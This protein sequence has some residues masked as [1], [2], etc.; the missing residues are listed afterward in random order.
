MSD[1]IKKIKIKQSD[2]TFSDYIP[3][4]ANAKDVDM[5]NGYSL[6][7][8]IGTIDVDKEGSIAKQLSKTTK[9]YDSVA[10]MKADTQL[11]GG[12]A[13]V[14]LGY[15]K[16]NDGG[17]ALYQIIDSTDE[18]Y[19]SLVD[20]GGSAH[21]LKNNLKAKLII[22]DSVNI[23]QFGAYGDG[24]HDD[25]GAIQ[26]TIN[27]IY[28]VYLSYQNDDLANI[29]FKNK[30]VI[31][32][33]PGRYRITDTIN[34]SI[35]IRIQVQGNAEIISDFDGTAIYISS[36]LSPPYIPGEATLWH[37]GYIG[38][39][40]IDSTVG[41][42]TIRKKESFYTKDSQVSGSIGLEIGNREQ[43]SS[44]M[45]ISRCS[46]NNINIYEFETALALNS[47]D[48]YCI[49][50]N[51]LH[52]E[53]NYYDIYWSHNSNYLQN[54]GE[55]IVFKDC[56]VAGAQYGLYL[57]ASAPGISF[58]DCS[59][60]FL[61]TCFYADGTKYNLSSIINF[62]NGHIEAIGYHKDGTILDSTKKGF[63]YIGYY[64]Y[65]WSTYKIRLNI[66]GTVLSLYPPKTKAGYKFGSSISSTLD[67]SYNTS[68][69]SLKNLIV[70]LKNIR[71]SYNLSTL[72]V[73]IE[74]MFLAESGVLLDYGQQMEYSTGCGIF[75]GNSYDDYIG[76]FISINSDNFSKY[77]SYYNVDSDTGVTI[78]TS[79]DSDSNKEIPLF[80]KALSFSKDENKTAFTLDRLKLRNTG[81]F[82]R[83]CIIYNVK[84]FST[85]ESMELTDRPTIAIKSY[86]SDNNPIY[87]YYMSS[88]SMVID[89]SQSEWKAVIAHFPVPIQA[90]YFNC[91]F[92]LNYIDSNNSA[93]LWNGTVN[94]A[95]FLVEFCN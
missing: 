49:T 95:G 19:E 47:T 58:E 33:I 46:F 67:K 83:V 4:G 69:N 87:S 11:T 82:I 44:Y 91:S 5:A 30:N 24:E 85:Q 1:R 88:N 89:S 21:D 17:G 80:T 10:D 48:L 39:S 59:F 54:S 86:L 73:E 81:K 65:L 57:N 93:K 63:G 25:T 2:G 18:D 23:K 51:N 43:Q 90:D 28:N 27:Y 38:G 3:I 61:G 68:A 14:T 15:Y 42:L 13:A 41:S 40:I 20:D 94:I 53:K 62:H 74:T 56:V 55:K 52:L 7:N 34:L 35:L 12:A 26:N 32:I 9:Y 50:F 16:P 79:E 60:D 66:D 64:D 37:Q 72:P 22:E 45:D 76:N 70:S 77:Y 29:L 31:K 78:Y 36:E 8:T 6:E 92:D 84:N 71:V 75:F